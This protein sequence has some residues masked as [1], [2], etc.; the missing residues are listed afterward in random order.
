MPPAPRLKDLQAKVA[1]EQVRLQV[2]LAERD[3]QRIAAQTKRMDERQNVRDDRAAYVQAQ[4][5]S[6]TTRLQDDD[7]RLVAAQ[8]ARLTRQRLTLLADL[9]Q[10][11]VAA[12]PPT[13]FAGAETLPHGPGIAQASLSQASLTASEDRLRTQRARW[14]KFL[15]DD[16][17]AAAQDM[18]AKQNWNVT[19]GPPRPGDRDLTTA[20]TQAMLP[21]I[22]RR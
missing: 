8:S 4:A 19:F 10:P 11:P 21:S 5:D 13:G 7:A 14:I 18:A 9:A 15:R 17:Q 22:W 16:T 20:M 12:V 6:L 2:L 1:S 3:R